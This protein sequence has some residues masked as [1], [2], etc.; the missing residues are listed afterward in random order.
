MV[1]S[2][3]AVMMLLVSP[4]A[5]KLADKIAPE[6]VSTAGMVI[7][8]LG[9]ALM[10]LINFQNAHYLGIISLI[11]FGGGIGLFYASNTKVVLSAV[12]NNYLGVASA[13][14]SNSRSLG[15]IFGLGIVS[16]VISA[17]MGQA[18]ITPSN[19][20]ELIESIRISLGA[21]ALLSGL[22]IFTSLFKD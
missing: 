18:Q 5:G 10:T 3:Q 12:D 17:I 1:V 20:P 11:I 6:N 9:V 4:F 21:I 14:L 13:T 16:L 15:Q 2:I 8:T 7:T 22:G 19:Y